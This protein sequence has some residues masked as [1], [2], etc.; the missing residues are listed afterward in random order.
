[1]VV[2]AN[3]LLSSSSAIIVSS[4]VF[5][6][7]I[8]IFP[9]SQGIFPTLGRQNISSVGKYQLNWKLYGSKRTHDINPGRNIVL[10][11]F[12]QAERGFAA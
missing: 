8:A 2:A 11:Y 9:L 1:M 3:I 4:G 7:N 10:F 5:K 12:L 6:G